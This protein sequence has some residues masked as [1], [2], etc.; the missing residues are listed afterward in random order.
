MSLHLNFRSYALQDGSP[1]HV[2]IA[3]EMLPAEADGR[4]QRAAAE[5]AEISM[6]GQKIYDLDGAKLYRHRNKFLIQIYSN[7]TDDCGRAAPLVCWGQITKGDL[8]AS[9]ASALDGFSRF[10]ASIGRTVNQDHVRVIEGALNGAMRKG[11][12]VS[13]PAA[14]TDAKSKVIPIVVG[15]AVIVVAAVAVYYAVSESHADNNEVRK[16]SIGM[17]NKTTR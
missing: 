10:A 14:F 2:Q 11:Q 4:L 9:G 7:E 15:A 5:V 12:P 16:G 17:V 13:S 1:A 8:R 3:G 6:K